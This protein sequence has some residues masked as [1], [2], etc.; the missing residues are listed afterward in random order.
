MRRVDGIGQDRCRL[1]LRLAASSD[2][3]SAD[4]CVDPAAAC[5]GRGLNDHDPRARQVESDE[6]VAAVRAN[7]VC[8]EFPL[9]D[10]EGRGLAE[11]AN[12]VAASA[13][14]LSEYLPGASDSWR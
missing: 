10:D 11:G 5:K 13:R 4:I 7:E 6:I 8:A 9:F 14:F 12:R 1:A 2:T 3:E